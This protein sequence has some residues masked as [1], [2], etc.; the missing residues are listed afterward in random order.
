MSSFTDTEDWNN[1]VIKLGFGPSSDTR[2]CLIT[3][4]VHFSSKI[5]W[6]KNGSVG[7]SGPWPWCWK[8][9]AS[10]SYLVSYRPGIL[11]PVCLS[12]VPFLGSEERISS[13]G[14]T[15]SKWQDSWMVWLSNVDVQPQIWSPEVLITAALFRPILTTWLDL[16]WSFVMSRCNYELLS[17]EIL[18]A[19]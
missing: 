14:G 13:L 9:W 19:F 10:F 4:K 15:H 16:L 1:K 8:K 2:M 12:P 17:H 7:S 6:L 3:T 18:I 11:T 5:L